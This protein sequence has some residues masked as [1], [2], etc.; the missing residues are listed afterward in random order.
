MNRARSSICNPGA[1]GTLTDP[2][3]MWLRGGKTRAVAGITVITPQCELWQGDRPPF[4]VSVSRSSPWEATFWCHCQQASSGEA[5][6]WGGQFLQVLTEGDQYFKVNDCKRPWCGASF[7][8]QCLQAYGVLG[9]SLR[10]IFARLIV[11]H[12]R[13]GSIFTSAY[14][15]SSK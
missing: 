15:V 7:W 5:W 10:S 3:Q 1:V 9:H 14:S 13:L 11:W 6:M 8:S 2:C 12:Q 4:G